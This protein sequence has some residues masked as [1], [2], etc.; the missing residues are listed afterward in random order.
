M[1]FRSTEMEKIRFTTHLLEGP[2][3]QLWETYQITHPLDGLTWEAFKEGY[4]NAHISTG[5]MNLKRDEFR[6]LRQGNRALREYMEDFNSLSRYAPED[7]DTDAKRKYKFLNGLNS[8]L[9]IP[10]SVAYA[11]NYQDILD[12]A[13][14]RT[15]TSRRRRIGKGS[16]APISTTLI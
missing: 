1:L 10:L 12:Q 6:T 9:K 5:I 3:A 15:A 13:I 8:E 14:L 7:V 11:P 4:R 16:S 2:A